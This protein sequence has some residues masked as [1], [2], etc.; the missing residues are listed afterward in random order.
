MTEIA[1]VDFSNRQS[2]PGVDPQFTHRW[3]PRA[4]QRTEI[5]PADLA[6]IFEAA[7]WSPSCFNDQPWRF[8]TSTAATFDTYLNLLNASNQTWAKN[9]AVLGFVVSR[10]HFRHNDKPNAYAD[11]D[12]GAA[13]MALTLQ[14]NSLGYHTHGMAGV[15]YD[16]AYEYLGLERDKFRIICGFA[17]GL[18]GDPANLT[19]EQRA[20]EAPSARVPL[21]EIWIPSD[22]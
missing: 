14:A 4:M 15:N 5:P 13:W 17:L 6:A 11:F 12:T 18:R 20:K 2:L 1:N 10:Q 22:K 19:P 16:A 3:S 7:R 21:N 8:Y 9:A